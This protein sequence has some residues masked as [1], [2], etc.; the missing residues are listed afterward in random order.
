MV[1]LS[2]VVTFYFKIPTDFRAKI[3]KTLKRQTIKLFLSELCVY[4]HTHTHK[5]HMFPQIN[6]NTK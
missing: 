5:L 1:H 6:D 3:N 4:T 2:N